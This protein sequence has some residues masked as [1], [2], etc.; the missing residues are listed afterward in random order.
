MVAKTRADGSV[1]E[2]IAAFDVTFSPSKSV[3]LLWGLSGDEKVRRI[4]LG[5]HETAVAA[6]LGYLDETAGHTRAGDG[7]VRKIAGDGFVIAQFRHRSS[8]STDPERRVGDPQLH[9]HCAILN[10]IR[11]VEGTWRTLDS[12]AIYRHAHVA[13]AVYGA[14]LERELSERLGVSWVTPQRRVPMREIAGVPGGLIDQF[15]TRRAAV[16]ATYQ[17]LEVEWWAMHGRTPT[18]VEKAG[19]MD[20]ATTR[21]RYRKA[22]GDVDLHEQWRAGVT[23]AELRGFGDVTGRGPEI[24]DGGRLPAGS[25]QLA[26]RVFS[27]LHEQRAWWTRAHVTAEVARLIADP[28]P[29]AIEVE[30][31]RIIAR[32]V[33]LEVDDDAE[34][35]DWG[36]AKYTSETIQNAEERVLSTATEDRATFAV[37]TL[38]DPALGDDQVA[39]VNEIARGGGRLATIV[40][41]AGAGKTTLLRSVAAT[42]RAAGRDVIVLTLSAAAARVVTDETGLEAHTIA[43]WRVGAVDMPR[44]GVVIVDEASMVPTLVLDEMV[45]VA[46]VYCSKITLIGDFAQMGAPEAG[47]LLRDLA[48][49]PTAVELTA[50]RRFRQP[51]EAD[52]SL[53]LRARQPDI[54]ATYWQQGRIVESSTDTVADDAAAAWWA[55]TAAGHR[56]LI[57]VDTASD[58]ADVNTRCQHHLIVAGHLGDHVADAADGSRIHIGDVIQ[59]RRN[60]A[61][62]PNSDRQR[63]LNRDVWTVTGINDDGS[64]H[65]KHHRRQASA[66]L[67]ADYVATD[68]VLGYAT[69]IAGAQCRT[70]DRG[71]VV[72][73]PRTTS[74]S[75]YVGMSR[76]R[77]SN[78]AHVVCDSHDHTEFELGDLTGEQAFAAAT[79]R[80][81]AGQLSAH[82]VQE[83][84]ET[85]RVDRTTARAADRKRRQVTDWWTVRV[86]GLP[87]A[88]RAAI[89]G[90]HHKVLDVLHRLPT[91]D[92][93]RDAIKSAASSVNWS[94]DGAADQFL[95]RLSRTSA[96][97]PRQHAEH[98]RTA[99]HE[100]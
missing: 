79:Q 16:L 75:L 40:G 83:R 46:G 59:T 42:Y 9:S 99:T 63:I 61:Q 3:S 11:G 10:R 44:G 24:S 20:E 21:S 29:E 43:G 25:P 67:P 76:G 98:G 1:A 88:M 72:V 89:A 55:D 65:V 49:L 95:Q 17:R 77:D 15:S 50:V 87:P 54:A 27:E 14:M 58:A 94:K 37:A 51:W 30:T 68:V 90:R 13:G 86:R 96:R 97:N 53:Q 47:G 4:V 69:T 70:V 33:S 73:T 78:H 80:D 6:G 52:A 74:A 71:H 38:R 34:Y 5:A 31:E 19:M 45:R 8:R 81:P 12:R 36:A 22:R 91:T 7:G 18:R 48:A 57:V 82:S 2:P 62:I 84:W 28:T 92:S 100:R 56:S 23:D 26:E 39:A 66:V 35:A 32:C 60:T 41:P 64:L 93:R 85:G